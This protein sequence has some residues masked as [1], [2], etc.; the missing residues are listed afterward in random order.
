MSD[1]QVSFC[2]K[3]IKFPERK[4][5]SLFNVRIRKVKC[6]EGFPSC[7]RCVS[8]GRKCDGYGIWGGG[9]NHHIRSQ[10]TT[11]GEKSIVLPRPAY[12]SSLVASTEE[13]KYFD[14]FKQRTAPKLPGSYISSFWTTLLLQAS[15][16]EPAVLHAV[17]ALSAVHKGDIP[18]E[19][20]QRKQTSNLE[21]LG[22]AE[23]FTLQHYVK[24]IK[25]L[26]PHF[27]AKNR[28]SFRIALISCIAFVSLEFLR[29][30]FTAAQVHLQN[31]LKLLKDAH[32]VE[33]R[34]NGILLVRTSDE[35]IDTW[36][37]EAFSRL[38]IQAQLFKHS[39]EQPHFLLQVA[40]PM[41]R[42]SVFYSFRMVWDELERLRNE[43]FLLTKE[44]REYD[45]QQTHPHC[46]PLLLRR[47]R[48]IK[49]DLIN[50]LTTSEASK[51]TLPERKL[52][53]GEKAYQLI[54][55]HHTMIS[56]MAEVCLCPN[57]EGVFDFHSDQ[58]ESLISE[59]IDLW[60]SGPAR[61]ISE[62]N[63]P[64]NSIRISRSIIDLGCIA[65]LHYTALKCRVHR[66]RVHAVRLLETLL[67]KEGIWDPRVSALIARKVIEIEE[68]DFYKKLH[69]D[70]DF[71]L[72]S[73]PS[74]ED[75]SLPRIPLSNRIHDVEITTLGDP[76]EK[77]SL[78]CKLE[79]DGA[80]SRRYGGEYNF[81][82]QCW[83]DV[84][85]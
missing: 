30:N 16:S 27:S 74:A 21:V 61:E 79:P 73:R 46:S 53:E 15:H 80:D 14:W 76:M 9:G 55:L 22:Q 7:R 75:L 43:I 13:K 20:H 54:F 35:Q 34:K 70:D 38:Y 17:L 64:Q 71:S 39:Y 49:A 25:G 72:F 24:A 48:M 83:M 52:P 82:S 63:H 62:S 8:T 81:A 5:R 33:S 77:V 36:I 51:D 44:A 4:G 65:P 84:G 60:R 11:A 2:T 56:I 12:F 42:P 45:A 29:G 66:I 28:A 23:Q 37:V 78:V 3:Q 26:Q 40:D 50:W 57:D 19:C 59:A 6:D 85:T 10:C 67:H 47:Q 18:N 58:F 68:R 31:G 1:L 69:I 32:L 41:F